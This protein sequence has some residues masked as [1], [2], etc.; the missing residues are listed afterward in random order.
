[1]FLIR[2]NFPVMLLEGDFLPLF[3]LLRS[4]MAKQATAVGLFLALPN[5]LFIVF[6]VG[7]FHIQLIPQHIYSHL[8]LTMDGEL[9]KSGR[10]Y[11]IEYLIM[12][13]AMLIRIAICAGMNFKDALKMTRY[14]RHHR[15]KCFVRSR[16]MKKIDLADN[17]RSYFSGT[18]RACILW[19]VG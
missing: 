10:N 16:K 13:K 6:L 19:I 11:G 17:I 3:S 14:K 18:K 15:R 12:R 2:I 8:P 4:K 1:M 7:C 9:T 5:K